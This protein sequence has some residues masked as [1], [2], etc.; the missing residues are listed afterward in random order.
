MKLLCKSVYVEELP[1]CILKLN[2]TGGASDC[3]VHYVKSGKSNKTEYPAQ[4]D[5][6]PLFYISRI[7]SIIVWGDPSLPTIKL[8]ETSNTCI[9]FLTDILTTN[10]CY[11]FIL[12][13]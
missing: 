4:K 9:F 8:S 5:P 3:K 12:Q 13:Y 10:K 6:N 2:V 11:K 7:P 1:V